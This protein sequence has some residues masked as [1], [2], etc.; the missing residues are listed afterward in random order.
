MAHT[1][2]LLLLGAAGFSWAQELPPFD[3]SKIQTPAQLI[4]LP[5]LTVNAERLD[6]A[7]RASPIDRAA[8]ERE[9]ETH[10]GYPSVS[11]GPG[12]SLRWTVPVDVGGEFYFYCL[13]RTG[14]QQGYEYVYPEMTYFATLDARP[15]ALEPVLE[16]AAV[17]VYQSKDSWGHD[18]G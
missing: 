12:V 8:A 3:R 10:G 4:G 17:R 7:G 9:A 14:H 2:L 18:M 1:A 11:V 6:A 13:C 5:L 15:V 16:V